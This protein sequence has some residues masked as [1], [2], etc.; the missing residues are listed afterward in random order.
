MDQRICRS[1]GYDLKMTKSGTRYCEHGCQTYTAQ[2]VGDEFL[3]A[4]DVAYDE[5][6]RVWETGGVGG[7]RRAPTCDD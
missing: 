7:I 3:V 5:E 2:P 6:G 4:R 1:C